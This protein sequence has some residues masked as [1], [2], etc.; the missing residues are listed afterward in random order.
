L[1]RRKKV[2]SASLC[3]LEIRL[4]SVGG[5]LQRNVSSKPPTRY[6]P[7]RSEPVPNLCNPVFVLFNC[8]YITRLPGERPG[9]RRRKP[10]LKAYVVNGE[11]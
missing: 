2:M 4:K 6:V 11:F 9:S 10:F 8:G 7:R 1:P 3:G 5:V